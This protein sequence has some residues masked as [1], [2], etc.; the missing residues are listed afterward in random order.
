MGISTRTLARIRKKGLIRYITPT[1]LRGGQGG[2]GIP[3][4]YYEADC[5][6][7]LAQRANRALP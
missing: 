5:N 6:A 7:Y 3:C 4:M 2:P 1:G